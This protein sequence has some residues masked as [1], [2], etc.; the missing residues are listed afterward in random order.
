LLDRI[1]NSNA[2]DG[3]LA[4]VDDRLRTITDGA[5]CF[6]AYQQQRVIA[7]IVERFGNDFRAHVSDDA[8]PV[9]PVL[10]AAISDLRDGV[11]VLDERQREKQP[12]WTFDP[13][14]SG[15]APAERLE[16]PAH[17]DR[18]PLIPPVVIEQ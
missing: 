7:S 3:D 6:L 18:A 14:D 5:R 8:P 2:S 16:A 13:E 12:D 15:K 9:E 4:A 10:I 17:A 1:R 11:T